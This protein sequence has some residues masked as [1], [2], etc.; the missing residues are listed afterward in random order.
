MTVDP[1]EVGDSVFS[2]THSNIRHELL[3]GGVYDFLI[4]FLLKFTLLLT[5]MP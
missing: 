5:I 1:K 3:Y 2:Y 4:I